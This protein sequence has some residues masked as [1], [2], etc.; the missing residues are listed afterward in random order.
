MK[1]R[2]LSFAFLL[3]M[4]LSLTACEVHWGGNSYDVHWWVIAIPTILFSLLICVPVHRLL[5]SKK[6]ICSVCGKKFR[7]KWY[8]FSLWI[9]YLDKHVAKCPH[10]GAK[11]L[12]DHVDE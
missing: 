6:Y 1:K 8:A 9:S 10:C 4:S 11:E 5:I 3:V 7:P 12:C 2:I